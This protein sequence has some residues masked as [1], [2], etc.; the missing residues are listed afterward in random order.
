M[1][2]PP[3]IAV[4]VALAAVAL[5]L[6]A[7]SSANDAHLK[8]AV[9][10]WDAQLIRAGK[11]T[12]KLKNLSAHERKSIARLARAVTSSDAKLKRALKRTKPSSATGRAVATELRAILPKVDAGAKLM[13]RG[14]RIGST[15]TA[16]RTI[17]TGLGQML[18]GGLGLFGIAAAHASWF[19]KGCLASR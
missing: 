18:R 1:R 12:A 11:S 13:L 19:P 10:T 7:A 17:G 6:P 16:A 2:R 9:C 14:T 8:K 15:R 4:L 5:A 3:L